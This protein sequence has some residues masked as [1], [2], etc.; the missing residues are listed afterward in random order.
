[1]EAS[2][3]PS[4][5]SQQA[6]PLRRTA[7]VCDA[8]GLLVREAVGSGLDTS[9]SKRP[10]ANASNTGAG[11]SK[12]SGTERRRSGPCRLMSNPSQLSP[13]VTCT[14]LKHRVQQYTSLH[15]PKPPTTFG[16]RSDVC[17]QMT[18]PFRTACPPGV[19][20]TSGG[21]H[22]PRSGP[23]VSPLPCFWKSLKYIAFKLCKNCGF[24]G[25]RWPVNTFHFYFLPPR[26]EAM[27]SAI[28]GYQGPT[29]GSPQRCICQYRMTANV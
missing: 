12:K 13:K 20:H 8:C 14:T 18:K 3:D 22:D 24:R 19:R 27:V 23:A 6:Q 16:T 29:N 2:P 26:S 9:V 15:P 11:S 28:E 10:W 17:E 5:P 25:S 7:C 4:S 1:M 21:H